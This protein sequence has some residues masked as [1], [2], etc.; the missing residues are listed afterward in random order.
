MRLRSA[1]SLTM[2]ASTVTSRPVVGSSNKSSDGLD[3]SAMAITTRC[4]WPP[5]IWVGVGGHQ[6][7]RVGQPHVGEHLPAALAGL[8][9][10]DGPRG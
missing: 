4:C 8:G 1:I 7:L 10:G 5:E 3:N 9:L 6:T 2:P